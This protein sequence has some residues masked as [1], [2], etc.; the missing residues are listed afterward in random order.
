MAAPEWPRA[1]RLLGGSADADVDRLAFQLTPARLL[2]DGGDRRTRQELLPLSAAGRRLCDDAALRRHLDLAVH[3]RRSQPIPLAQR[4]A[5][6]GAARQERPL[7]LAHP[8]SAALACAGDEEWRT[9]R[10]G[11]RCSD[12]SI[13]SS[14]RSP[15]SSRDFRRPFRGEPGTRS[16]PGCAHRRVCSN[17]VET[18]WDTSNPSSTRG[19]LL[20]SR[21]QIA[22]T[23]C[24]DALDCLG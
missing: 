19:R 11:K 5:R 17:R 16:G 1:C 10:C 9:A 23:I 13:R 24:S 12:W 21:P 3:R 15:P 22:S 8:S 20:L 7:R 6:D 14:R 4:R 2:A 18:S